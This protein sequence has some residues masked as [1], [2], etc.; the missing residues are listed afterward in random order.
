MINEEFYATIKLVSGEEIFSLV[1]PFEEENELVLV[2][3][4]PVFIETSYS[5]TLKSPIV[6]V[7]P[8]M[9]LTEDTTFI[10]GLDKIITMTEI[11]DE[12]FIKI[13]K[14]YVREFS[15]N[16]TKSKITPSMGYVTT[17][18]K[19]RILLERLY[20]SPTIPSKFE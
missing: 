4:H 2:L 14:R 5:P 8:W 10:V 1:C 19:S 7:N 15:I 16:P 6:K 13:H 20:Q 11:Y 3:D 17:V 12:R 9:R 18:S